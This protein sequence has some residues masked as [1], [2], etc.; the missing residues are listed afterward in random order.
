M[1]ASAFKQSRPGYV[2][3]E[4]ELLAYPV[5]RGVCIYTILSEYIK[6]TKSICKEESRLFI[7]YVKPHKIVSSGTIGTWVKT[8]MAKAGINTE[9]YKAQC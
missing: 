6:R 1:G 3:P 4:F 7:Y 9:Q 5:I 2:P 8:M